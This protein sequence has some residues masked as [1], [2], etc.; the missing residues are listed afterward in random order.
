MLTYITRRILL[1]F[2]TLFG[3]TL[4]VFSVMAVAPGGIGGAALKA[5]G[6][7]QSAEAR[8]IREYYNQ[9]YGLDKP[10]LVQYVRWLNQISP[11]GFRLREDRSLGSL[12][13]KVP[14]LGESLV[15]HRPV[16]TLIGESLPITLM[17]NLI[18]FP[19]VYTVG[20][21]TGM[22]AARHRGKLLDVGL[23]TTQ[24]ALWSIPVIWTGVMLIGFLAN[25][26]YI[27]LFPT[28]GL[29]DPMA[30]E[31]AFLP[32]IT[33][34]GFQ[35]GWLL[36]LLWHLVLP[37]TCMVYGGGA[38]LA[39]L[40]RGSILENLHQDYVRTARAKG[41]DEK[42]VFFQHVLRNSLLPLITVFSGI[43]P[44]MLAGSVIIESIFSIPGMGRLMVEAVQYRDKELVMAQTLVGGMLVLASEII[45]DICYAIADPRVSYE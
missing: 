6:G 8:R 4:L 41:V 31:M 7:E 43:L 13:F 3:I 23:G 45:R 22:L 30:P 44:A 38:V 12:G 24:L 27:K 18:A 34:A 39:K 26:Q 5:A 25:K 19:I 2:P 21:S 29:G 32:R 15:R 35:R 42:T 36:D 28:S 37:V 14:D 9:R 11:V 33:E 17:L 10:V 40:T 16:L 1:L 20:L